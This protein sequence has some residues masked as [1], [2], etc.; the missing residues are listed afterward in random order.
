MTIRSRTAEDTLDATGKKLKTPLDRYYH[1]LDRERVG[2]YEPG[3]EHG[4]L[5]Q[6]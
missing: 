5:W 6:Q 4:Y 3:A 1:R 2:L